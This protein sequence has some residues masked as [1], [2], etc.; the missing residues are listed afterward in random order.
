MA[1][2]E[3]FKPLATVLSVG[4]TQKAVK[5]IILLPTVITVTRS[6]LYFYDLIL[7]LFYIQI[8]KLLKLLLLKY[9]IDS[10][11]TTNLEHLVTQNM[12]KN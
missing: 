12:N 3:A 4:I 5:K 8:N 9:L 1:V 10:K 6:N 7:I 2:S 11:I